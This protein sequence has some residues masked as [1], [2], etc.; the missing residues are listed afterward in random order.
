ME[1]AE[2][3]DSYYNFRPASVIKGFSHGACER[4]Q[5]LKEY[6]KKIFLQISTLSNNEKS[7]IHCDGCGK[8]GVIK[9]NYSNCS[10]TVKDEN[11]HSHDIKIICSTCD[12]LFQILTILCVVKK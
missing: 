6:F 1:L 8:S 5:S 2:N 4:K 7:S 3:L 11:V 9:A 12:F 10:H